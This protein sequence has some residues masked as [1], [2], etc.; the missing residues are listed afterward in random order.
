MNREMLLEI[1]KV[2]KQFPGTKALDNVQLSVERGEVHALCGENGAGKSTLMNI[3]GGL[4]PPTD[5]ELFF[6]GKKIA[7]KN[8]GEAQKIGIGFVHQELSLC[9]HLTVAENI[10]IGR[11]PHK[12]DMIDFPKLWENADEVLSRFGANFSSKTKVSD[13]TV[14]EQ[15][16]VEIAKSVSLDCKLLILDE[17]TSSLTDKETR[18]LFEVVRS[19]K[20]ENI[21]ILFISHR[22]PEIF[23]IC[24][25]VSVFK[26]GRYVCTMNV[27]EINADDIIRAMVG[28]ELGNLYPP[29]SSCIDKTTELLKVENLS[30]KIFKDVSFELY[31]GE[32]LGFA[33]LVGAGRSEIMTAL[34]GIDKKTSGT[35]WVNGKAQSFKNYRDA[36]DQ[37]VCYLTED[38]KKQGLYLD[39][40][41]KSNM[42][43][44]NLKAVSKGIWLQEKLEKRLADEYVKR[45]SIKVAGIEYPISSLSGGNQ[46]KCLL[47]K[48]LSIKPK[49]I[50]VDEP[51]RGIDVGA[52][53]EIHNLLRTLADEG[54]GVIMISSELPEVMGVSDR[55]IVVHEG[56]LSGEISEDDMMTEEN[57]MRLASGEAV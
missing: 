45:L 42:A 49:I 26:D 30:G 12:G 7:P 48:W 36:V 29:K 18:K 5:G 33:G 23:A 4:Y 51:T 8:P 54:V 22:M 52:K 44:A 50:I 15:Q 20:Q 43:S 19:L 35:V 17:P 55:V 14:S 32:I 34:C 39:M 41:I 16:L 38:R 57:I 31:K 21:S 27:P 9:P 6:E 47:G 53:L 1:K 37:G 28:R 24:D 13:L 11:L 56:H 25:R 46:Q 10:Y 40:S 3:I 2:T